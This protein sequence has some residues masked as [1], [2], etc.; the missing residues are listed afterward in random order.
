MSGFSDET[1]CPN[2][3]MGCDRY[4]DWKPF[5]YSVIQCYHC[6]LIISP[7]IEYLSLEELN[8][9]RIDNEMEELTELPKQ[10]KD[11]W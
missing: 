5:D 6:G 7:Q 9:V 2:C 10:E 4:T 3:G 1:Y 8:D 11:L